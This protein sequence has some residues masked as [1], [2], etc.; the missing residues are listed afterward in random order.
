MPG[1]YGFR[2][3]PFQSKDPGREDVLRFAKG[4]QP[5]RGTDLEPALQGDAC[6]RGPYGQIPGT[7]H[8]THGEVAAEASGKT[9]G[10]DQI[11]GGH[12]ECVASSFLGL[13]VSHAGFHQEE[14][15]PCG[16]VVKYSKGL[17]KQ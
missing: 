5:C 11:E 4:G 17:P 6:G 10:Y 9:G 12:G 16:A 14:F 1:E 13:L 3:G 7:N 2:L 8:L 15:A